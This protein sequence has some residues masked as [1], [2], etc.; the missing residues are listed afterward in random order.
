MSCVRRKDCGH[1][2]LLMYPVNRCI[3]I[4]ESDENIDA[5][6]AA[7]LHKIPPEDLRI[8]NDIARVYRIEMVRSANFKSL[9]DVKRINRDQSSSTNIRYRSEHYQY[10]SSVG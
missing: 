4:F 7:N 1:H 6:I 8:S 2:Q 5:H 9:H 10:F 3:T